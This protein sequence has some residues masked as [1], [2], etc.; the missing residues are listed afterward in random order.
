M[1]LSLAWLKEY[2][3]IDISPEKFG[4]LLTLHTVEVEGVKN[5]AQD[6]ENIVVGRIIKIE[7]HPNADKL[8]LVMVDIGSEKCRVVCGGGNLYEGMLVV[9][10]KIGAQVRWHG[11]GDLVALGKATIRGEESSGMI[12]A[13]SEIG[14]ENLFPAK[15][16]DEVVDLK[17]DYKVGE[18]LAT[19][20]GMDD[21]IF[22][23]DNKSM[24]HRP[25][26]WSHYGL[27]R[28]ISVW[29][30]KPLKVYPQSALE[31]AKSNKVLSVDV[32]DQKICPRYMAITIDGIEIKPSAEKIQNRLRACGMRPINNVVD[33][34]NYVMLEIGQPTHAFD[35]KKIGQKISI[36]LAK[37]NEAITTLDGEKR[38]LAKEML[39]ITNGQEPVAIAGVMGA[40]NSEIDGATTSITLESANFDAVSIRKTSQ[41]LGLRTESSQRYEKSL[42]PN[43]C[44]EALQ[45]IFELIKKSCPQA[46]VV[47]HLVDIHKFKLNQGPIE[48]DVEWLQK[49]IGSQIPSNKAAEILQNLGFTVSGDKKLI[50]KVPTWRATKDISIPEDI[51][52]EVARI[53]GYNNIKSEMPMVKMEAPEKN[54][55]LN[56]RNKI[57]D[58]LVQAGL[59]ETYN[60]AF[61][62]EAQVKK[63]GLES[64]FYI[65]LANP[66]TNEHTLLRR[67][68]IPHLIQNVV[69]NQRN[70]AVI[71]LFE[72]GNI[73]ISEEKE[74]RKDNK[75]KEKLPKQKMI[76][77]L[78]YARSEKEVGENFK[79]LKGVIE[80]LAK[81]L[82]L[83][84]QFTTSVSGATLHL[85]NAA[86]G[87][88]RIIDKQTAKK[89]GLK[90]DAV[91]A[92]LEISPMLELLKTK[93]YSPKNKYPDLIRDLAFV[94]DEKVLYN[95][96]RAEIM[97]VNKL[98]R[99]VEVF[100]IYIG[101]KI[102][103]GKKNIAMH[104]TF[105]SQEK[106]LTGEEVDNVQKKIVVNLNKKFNASL[107]GF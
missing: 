39:L 21:V 84:F 46:R 7:A 65:K 15:S 35:T 28:D 74:L 24:T 18:N 23:I 91:V 104:I 16:D 102:A 32:Q 67:N 36:R 82:D 19:A 20:L 56:F 57:K 60:Y 14:L 26:L 48:V 73:F 87:S 40:G 55:E 25:D 95:D 69:T 71:K 34:T 43:L 53:Y 86:V 96:I 38:K 44:A 92:E 62:N 61:V 27:A 47:S 59:S 89:N 98:I 68:L 1:L 49:K 83:E 64:D 30:D 66:L 88:L 70:F 99:D 75:T 11:Q 9:F 78:V 3:D 10:A 97:K 58:I 51:I 41:K 106:T 50:V 37:Q 2:V 6:F 103:V 107:R 101:D 29:L 4:E 13:S 105:A 90:T 12:C 22:D 77:G 33:I 80:F 100:D 31:V 79:K 93:T 72:I 5:L 45:R 63:L 52:E 8:K 42:D 76:L 85:N 17:G 94:I 54:V 81:E